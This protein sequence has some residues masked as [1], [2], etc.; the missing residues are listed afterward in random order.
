[1][2]V[3]SSKTTITTSNKKTSI[4]SQI[5]KKKKFDGYANL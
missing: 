2:M 4:W 5:Y 1:M 3:I